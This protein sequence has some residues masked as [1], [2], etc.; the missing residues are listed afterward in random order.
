MQEK[1]HKNGPLWFEDEAPIF[2]KEIEDEILSE[3]KINGLLTAMAPIFGAPSLVP[4]SK[5]EEQNEELFASHFNARMAITNVW[6]EI[7]RQKQDVQIWMHSSINNSISSQGCNKLQ[8]VSIGRAHKLLSL[9]QVLTN[10][11]CLNI[12]RKEK[13]SAPFTAAS[14]SYTIFDNAAIVANQFGNNDFVFADGHIFDNA[15][16]VANQ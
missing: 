2:N 11:T 13:T 4:F 14:T 9:N 8:L 12:A 5:W 6:S 15:D 3:H 10:Y 7:V 1:K 16:I